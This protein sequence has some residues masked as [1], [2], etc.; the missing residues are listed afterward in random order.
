[1]A[2][3]SIDQQIAELQRKKAQEEKI[4]KD[5]ELKVVDD[6]AK[7]MVGKCV[8]TRFMGNYQHGSVQFGKITGYNIVDT[9]GH[10]SAELKAKTIDV[11]LSYQLINELHMKGNCSL[12]ANAMRTIKANTKK[13]AA[14]GINKILTYD[15]AIGAMKDFVSNTWTKEAL[16]KSLIEISQEEYNGVVALAKE[17]DQLILDRFSYILSES[18]KDKL[19]STATLPDTKLDVK[20][21]RLQGREKYLLTKINKHIIRFI[22]GYDELIVTDTSLQLVKQICS[23]GRSEESFT[24]GLCAQYG[25]RYRNSDYEN[26][27]ELENKIKAIYNQ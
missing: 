14:D 1:M 22:N 21:Y 17:V 7:T 25:E 2:E 27:T 15:F 11:H 4:K 19:L 20:H 8:R 26:Y 12:Y 23:K 13:K 3:L 16:P 10:Y 6:W 18:F 5:K 24:A 9:N